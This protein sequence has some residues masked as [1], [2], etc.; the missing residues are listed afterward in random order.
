MV[1]PVLLLALTVAGVTGC[2]TA[3]PTAVPPAVLSHAGADVDTPSDRA[4]VALAEDRALSVDTYTGSS[5]I[6]L[7]EVRAVIGGAAGLTGSAFDGLPDTHAV[8]AC[9]FDDGLTVTSLLVDVDGRVALN[10]AVPQ[11]RPTP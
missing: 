11:A 10:P 9:F 5:A 1:R 2:S 7:A 3:E 6:T 8:D 4:C